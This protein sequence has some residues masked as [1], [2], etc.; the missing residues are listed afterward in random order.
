MAVRSLR[1]MQ[2]K[3]TQVGHAEAS[4]LVKDC[5]GK[6]DATHQLLLVRIELELGSRRP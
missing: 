2:R 3:G 4:Q 1:S 5:F 6:L